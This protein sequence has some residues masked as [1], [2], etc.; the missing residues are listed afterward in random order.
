MLMVM[1]LSRPFDPLC[2]WALKLRRFAFFVAD[3]DG[4]CL[5]KDAVIDNYRARVNQPAVLLCNPICD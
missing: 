2:L 5:E 1:S 3:A 4:L